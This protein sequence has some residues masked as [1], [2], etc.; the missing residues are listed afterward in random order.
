MLNCAIVRRANKKMVCRYAGFSLKKSTTGNI[1]IDD[2]LIYDDKLRR[3]DVFFRVQRKW[4]ILKREVE[5][6]KS[7]RPTAMDL[8]EPERERI[9]L[10]L[11]A[12]TNLNHND[13][14]GFKLGIAKRAS[15]KLEN[16]G[17]IIKNQN[18]KSILMGLKSLGD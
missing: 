18:Q 2:D 12:I 11:E 15:L 17:D 10:L 14:V 9:K 3:D 7:T 16:D 1:N 8:S 13:L 4:G 6:K 5:L